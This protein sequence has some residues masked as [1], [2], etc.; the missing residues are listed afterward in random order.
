[1]NPY[2]FD[3]NH[4]YQRLAKLLLIKD[5]FLHF[6]IFLL[7][8]NLEVFAFR[9]IYKVPIYVFISSKAVDLGIVELNFYAFR[10]IAV[11]FGQLVQCILSSILAYKRV[12][13]SGSMNRAFGSVLYCMALAA[14]LNI[15]VLF[16]TSPTVAFGIYIIVLTCYAFSVILNLL[17][18]LYVFHYYAM[19]RS[20]TW[21]SKIYAPLFIIL[22][23]LFILGFFIPNGIILDT[24]K[25]NFPTYS[26]EYGLYASLRVIIIGIAS[27][28]L[29]MKIYSKMTR[30]NP[31]NYKRKWMIYSLITLGY[32]IGLCGLVLINTG[33]YA[34]LRTLWYIVFIPLFIGYVILL[35]YALYSVGNHIK[36]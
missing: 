20:N 16:I 25:A 26:L 35:Y 29:S 1:V 23:A 17:F 27:F 3:P 13:K 9:Q 24:T 28:I 21:M 31:I 4:N 8:K 15:T 22:F 14:L 10:I 34:L 12:K 7:T 33:T 5:R 6:M 19:D 36:E 2:I 32:H 30:S 18:I 11:I